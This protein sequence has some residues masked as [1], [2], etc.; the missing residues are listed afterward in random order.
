VKSML[1]LLPIAL[2]LFASCAQAEDVKPNNEIGLGEYWVFYS[3]TATDISGPFTPPGLN[4]DTKNTT[5]PYIAYIRRIHGNFWVEL[6]A[7][8]PPLTKSVGK[9]PE[10]LGSVPYNGQV[11]T[12]ARWLAPSLLLKY[13]F[14]DESFIVRPYVEA[15]VNYV[16]FYDRNSTPAG[17]AGAGG[18]T[19]IELPSSVG[20]AGTIGMALHLSRNWGATASWSVSRVRTHLTAITG[21]VQRTSTISFNPQALVLAVTYAF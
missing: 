14:L 21:D 12:T 8:I 15:G 18:P 2:A 7:G 10:E 9:G 4:L 17:N 6:T 13:E 1:R 3:V 5:T 11:I 19:R 16:V 20:P